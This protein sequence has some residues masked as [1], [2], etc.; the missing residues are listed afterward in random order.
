MVQIDVEI[1]VNQLVFAVCNTMMIAVMI[2]T[3]REE[4]VLI[5][6]PKLLEAAITDT[7]N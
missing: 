4:L 6:I 7:A 1:V 5:A 3:N 2:R